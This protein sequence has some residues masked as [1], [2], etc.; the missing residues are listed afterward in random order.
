MASAEFS[1]THRNMARTPHSVALTQE[2][3][4]LYIQTCTAYQKAKVAGWS[5]AVFFSPAELKLLLTLN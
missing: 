1:G 5:S 3:H 2:A 4:M